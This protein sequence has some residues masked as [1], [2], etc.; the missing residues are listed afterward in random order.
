MG[1]P[2]PPPAPSFDQPPPPSSCC[3]GPTDNTQFNTPM[4]HLGIEYL[5]W[6]PRK[7]SLPPLV[8]QGNTAQATPGVLSDPRNR[9]LLQNNQLEDDQLQ[10]LRL[11]FG[12]G[13]DASNQWSFLFS[14][15]SLEE[16]GKTLGFGIPANQTTSVVLARPFFN[17]ATGTEDAVVF[18]STGSLAGALQVSQKR[19]FYGGDMDLRYEYLCS[20]L[21]RIHLITGIKLLFL[22]E[23]LNFGV[24]TNNL[25]SGVQ[26]L[27]AE[28]L[29]AKNRFYGGNVGASWE[30]RLG[31]VFFLTTA[32]VAVG[33]VDVNPTFSAYTLTANPSG[34]M[35]LAQGQGLFVS[36]ATA[37]TSRTTKF[38]VAPELNFK[39][40]FD[41]N[42]YVRLSVGY[43]FV[44]L[45]GVAR[46]GDLINRNLD[47]AALT[48]PA[49]VRDPAVQANVPTSMFWAQGLDVSLRF[50]F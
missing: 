28:S 20:D 9:I 23:S 17:T 42:E 10:G 7:S 35:T 37:G 22:E 40:G 29:A 11:T 48:R 26:T 4:Y 46:S 21:T 47:P 24:A 38:A 50:S 30:Q 16:G 13:L 14:A 8:T 3:E 19:R 18:A 1:L 49:Q 6:Y 31:P 33:A 41:F 5:Y 44:G 34:T 25:N 27:Q 15:F 12:I 2:C 43:T 36:P 45:T 32:K 39:V